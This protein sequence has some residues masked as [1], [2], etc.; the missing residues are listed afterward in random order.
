MGAL[1]DGYEIARQKH[2]ALLTERHRKEVDVDE[3]LRGLAGLLEEDKDFMQRHGVNCT[4]AQRIL[5]VNYN[6]SPVVTV[7][8]EPEH[9]T[10]RVTFMSDGSHVAPAT[11]EESARAIGEMLF[12]VISKK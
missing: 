10:F 3:H 12:N 8:Y 2:E 4:V 7:H 11:V 5:H 9:K 6:R 1:F